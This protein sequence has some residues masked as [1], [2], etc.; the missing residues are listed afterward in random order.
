M[1]LYEAGPPLLRPGELDI[2]GRRAAAR[3]VPYSNEAG[4]PA[5][6][7]DPAERRFVPRP[8]RGR[9]VAGPPEA[10]AWRPLLARVPG[11]PLLIGPGS[12]AEEVWGSYRAA[13]EAV[14]GAGRGAYLLDPPPAGL[15]SRARGGCVALFGW[16]PDLEQSEAVAAAVRGGIPSGLLLPVIPGWTGE[17]DFLESLA[18]WSAA[19]GLLFLAPVIPRQDGEARRS[20]VEARGG[21]DDFFESIHHTD[22][23]MTLPPLLDAARRIGR[24]RGLALLPPRPT[25]AAEP[26]GNGPAAARLEERAEAAGDDEHR[27]SLLRAAARWIDESGRDLAAILAEGN[28]R[29]VFPFAPEISNEAEAAFA[30]RGL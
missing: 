10:E 23:D 5:F 11:G 7:F 19:A 14:L 22:W 29:K 2:A 1:I 13:A 21:G 17:E 27:A 30:E 28:F 25:G 6:R 9:V 16:H 15:P 18:E 26:P 8:P 4:P 3:L 20:L 24:R 12:P